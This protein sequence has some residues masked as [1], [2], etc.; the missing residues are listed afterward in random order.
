MLQLAEDNVLTFREAADTYL[1][2]LKT[3]ILLHAPVPRS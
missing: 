1:A 3:Q 2:L